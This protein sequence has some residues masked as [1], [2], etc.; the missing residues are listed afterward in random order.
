MVNRA[1]Q[2]TNALSF[3]IEEHFQVAAF[4]AAIDRTTWCDQPSRVARNTHD[5]LEL[6]Q[7]SAVKA[8]FF[9]LG[10]VAERQPSLVRAIAAEGHEIACHGY[11]H[12]LIYTQDISDFRQETTRSRALLEDIAQV[13]V[14]AY[15][16]ASYS[17]TQDSLWALD[18][19]YEAGF[20]TDSSIFPIRHDLYGLTGGPAD[21]HLIS[22][23]NGGTLLEFPITTVRLAGVTLPVSGGG[24][25]RLYPY[26]LSRMLARK[27]NN[28][29]RPLMFYLHPWE[30]DPDQPQIQ[31]SHF[32]RFRHYNNL[33]KTRDRLQRI[34]GDFRFSTMSECL[35]MHY[36]DGA[37][38]TYSYSGPAAD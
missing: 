2:L 11:S 23:P 10:W 8:T 5:L 29:G 13:P 31:A 22:L 17:I 36:A 6:L 7:K 38:P 15:R 24:Y 33:K 28:A 1:P 21:P 25:F 16:A 34:I 30:I 4:D 19:L 35:S 27:V 37:M 18:I 32:S 3:D 9:I 20:R 26:G 12:R 14:T